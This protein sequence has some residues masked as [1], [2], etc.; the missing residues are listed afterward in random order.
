MAMQYLIQLLIICGLQL[1]LCGP[2]VFV[3]SVSRSYLAPI[4][5]A[6]CTLMVALITGSTWL[7]AYLPWSVPALQLA[8]SASAVFPL[9]MASYIIPAAT[10][11]LG[12]VGTWG[13]VRWTDQK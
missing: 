11:I 8:G 5:Y 6:F 9:S 4:A 2:V 12:L 10:G 1:L 13:W 7:G 3:A